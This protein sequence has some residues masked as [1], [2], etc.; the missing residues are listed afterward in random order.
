MSTSW[1]FLRQR[2]QSSFQGLPQLS[3]LEC[4]GGDLTP[5]GEVAGE[6]VSVLPVLRFVDRFVEVCAS[7]ADFEVGFVDAD[8]GDPGAEFAFPA[9]PADVGKRLQDGFLSRLFRVCLVM[10]DGHGRGE[11]QSFAR[12]DELIERFPTPCPG[13]LHKFRFA[14]F[15][16][17]I[18]R[19]H[20]DEYLH[21]QTKPRAATLP[22]LSFESVWNDLEDRL[23]RYRMRRRK[24][25]RSFFLRIFFSRYLDFSTPFAEFRIPWQMNDSITLATNTE[26]G[27]PAGAAASAGTTR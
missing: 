3:P 13:L 21:Q 12:L 9:E 11:Q 20:P 26:A 6:I 18:D 10:K 8:L 4:L 25:G 5:V 16:R 19:F 24:K 15:Q 14:C 22:A 1:Y 7:F 17:W 27:V 2:G 23:S